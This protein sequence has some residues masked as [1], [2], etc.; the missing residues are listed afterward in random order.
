MGFRRSGDLLFFFFFCFV[1]AMVVLYDFYVIIIIIIILRVGTV[2][3]RWLYIYIY[4]EGVGR[5]SFVLRSSPS[6]DG[7]CCRCSTVAAMRVKIDS[8]VT[9]FKGCAAATRV[10]DSK[11]I[12]L[13]SPFAVYTV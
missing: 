10:R 13:V 9:F 4:T 11:K 5:D 2:H 6:I 1:V 3:R 7:G 8:D 12:N